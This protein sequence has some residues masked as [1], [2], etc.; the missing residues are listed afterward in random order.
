ML[1]GRIE[2]EVEDE[3]RMTD[4]E[5]EDEIVDERIEIERQ[6][7]VAS[8]REVG[9]DAMRCMEKDEGVWVDVA[10]SRK[11]LGT[12]LSASSF[13]VAFSPSDCLATTF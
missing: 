8:R 4:G 13:E 5:G 9:Q 2:R 1:K 11:E 7:E 10:G 6:E 12:S 3:R